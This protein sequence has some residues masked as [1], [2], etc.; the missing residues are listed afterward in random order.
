MQS[1]QQA[2]T[3]PMKLG[4]ICFLA[5]SQLGSAGNKNVLRSWQAGKVADISDE[6]V[7]AGSVE[8]PY[9]VFGERSAMYRR[10]WTYT[11]DAG[12][13]LYIVREV[14]SSRAKPC[15]L[16]VNG[17]VRFA[18]DKFFY[19]KDDA[20]KEHKLEIAKKVLKP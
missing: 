6:R 18:I 7:Y 5:I 10:T 3:P 16:S 2:D 8:M 9:S 4:V 15:E 17:P 19:I 12:D 11:I 20:G 14:L 1:G 13:T